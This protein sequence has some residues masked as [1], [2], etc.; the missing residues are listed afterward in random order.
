MIMKKTRAIIYLSPPIA[1]VLDAVPGQS[2]SGR[3]AD[4]CARYLCMVETELARVRFEPGEWEAI[5]R[6][7]EQLGDDGDIS[8]VAELA[9]F[10]VAIRLAIIEQFERD[11][12]RRNSQ[13]NYWVLRPPP[14]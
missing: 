12:A 9:R 5:C 6:A 13:A 2:V 7:L 11:A 14:P 8:E 1:A 4:V 3:L 10:S